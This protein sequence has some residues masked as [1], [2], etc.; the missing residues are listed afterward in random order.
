MDEIRLI[1][2]LEQPTVGVRQVVRSDGLPDVFA[3]AVPAVAQILP[4]LGAVPAGAPYARYRGPLSEAV[5]VEVGFPVVEPV[6]DDAVGSVTVPGGELRADHLPAVRAVE[7][8]H[9]GSY[10]E[11]AT[12]YARMEDWV[13]EHQLALLDQSWEIYEAGP[14]S[15]PDPATWRTRIVL[16]VTGP[17]VGAG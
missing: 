11:L 15:D 6:P 14:E 1:E 13:A 12:T 10:E 17:A 7:A 16:P 3:R 9:A 2:R 8:V 4:R 5:D